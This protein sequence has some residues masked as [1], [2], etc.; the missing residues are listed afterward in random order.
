MAARQ[1][2]SAAQLFTRTGF[3]VVVVLT[4]GML[5][6][7]APGIV[8]ETLK[9]QCHEIV[10][11]QPLQ[12]RGIQ[13]VIKKRKAGGGG[14]IRQ[15]QHERQFCRES[16]L[17]T[18]LYADFSRSNFY[19]KWFIFCLFSENIVRHHKEAVIKMVQI[20]LKRQ[21]HKIIDPCFFMILTDPDPA[22][23]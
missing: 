23:S 22:H 6:K 19:K 7:M 21:C 1:S 9:V 8:S 16:D 4:S 2:E 17:A 14:R 11:F 20:I 13:S 3:V 12:T 10:I 5:I 18:A 15:P